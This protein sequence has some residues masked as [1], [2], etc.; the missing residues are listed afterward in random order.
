VRVSTQT[1]DLSKKKQRSTTSSY[2]YTFIYRVCTPSAE[3]DD[4]ERAVCC[5]YIYAWY[6]YFFRRFS[7]M[8]CCLLLLVYTCIYILYGWTP[9]DGGL[10]IGET[11]HYIFNPP[12]QR[13]RD[14]GILADVR[15]GVDFGCIC[16]S[17][18]A[19]MRSRRKRSSCRSPR[20][21]VGGWVGG[22]AERVFS[23][24]AS[25]PLLPLAKTAQNPLWS[26]RR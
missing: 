2:I 11:R 19:T 23:V 10:Y 22:C 21:R 12:P 16:R 14:V 4:R 7:Y 3:S 6:M 17:R 24:R 25:L 20:G 18:A 15:F 8:V 5:V 1:E 26:V 9:T 13:R